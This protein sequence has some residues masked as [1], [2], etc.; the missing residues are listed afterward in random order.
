MAE[1][2]IINSGIP[3]A[4]I[5]PN[6]ANFFADSIKKAGA[7]YASYGEGKVSNKRKQDNKK[8]EC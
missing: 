8:Q 7:F 3:Y 4:F 5:C 6:F 1:Q 2:E